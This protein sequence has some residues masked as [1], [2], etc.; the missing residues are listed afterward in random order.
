MATFRLRKPGG[1]SSLRGGDGVR[2]PNRTVYEY[3]ASGGIIFGGAAD[4]S[5]VKAVVG[6]GGIVFG[7]E[8][9]VAITRS[10]TP[11]GG[12]VLGGE[13]STEFVDG[14]GY[15]GSGGLLFGGAATTS[16]L[17]GR[18]QDHGVGMYYPMRRSGVP[19]RRKKTGELE[20]VLVDK[21]LDE[22]EI[23][24]LLLC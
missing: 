7:G 15:V 13:A 24:L 6:T 14:R 9:G 12:I 19:I 8:A 17:S 2:A 1:G 5:T 21:D 4:V 22:D 10:F 16:F 23:L 20:D 11:P 18:K 3:A